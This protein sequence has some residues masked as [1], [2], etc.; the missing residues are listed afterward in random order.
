MCHFIA[1]LFDPAES[2]EIAK[3]AHSKAPWLC[4]PYGVEQ[5]RDLS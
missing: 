4:V 2:N 5:R 3:V 1:G